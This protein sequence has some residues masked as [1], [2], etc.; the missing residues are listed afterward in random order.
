MKILIISIMLFFQISYSQ[1]EK[2]LRVQYIETIA[3]HPKIVAR[4]MGILYVSENYSYYKVEPKNIE[5]KDEIEVEETIITGSQENNYRFSEVI[6]NKKEKKLTERLYENIFIKKH[7]AIK[8]NLPIMKWKLIN[9]EKTIKNFICKK[10]K[11]IFRGRS[12]T[13]WY[14]EKI[15]ISSG[16]WKFNSLPGLIISVSDDSGIYKWEANSLKYPYENKEI[17]FKKI[18]L[19]KSKY[20]PI[21]YKDFDQKRIKAIYDKIE[22]IRARNADRQDGNKVNF[23]YSTFLDKEPINEWRNEN[24]FE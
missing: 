22:T 13:A 18:I 1:N 9:E 14:T 4:N 20:Q 23:S 7:Y 12:Y 24:N 21:S 19:N 3:Q 6:V 16:P 8:E 11:I 15:Q 17:D 2:I 10:A 5:K